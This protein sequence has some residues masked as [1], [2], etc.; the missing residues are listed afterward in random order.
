MP[1]PYQNL[2]DTAFWRPAVADRS[3]FDLDALWS[4]K[5]TVRPEDGVATYG[6]CFAQHIGQALHVRGF[7]WTIAEAAP[8]G[9][10]RDLALKYS[11]GVFS[12]RTGNIY[13]T[14]LLNQWV[15]W[16]N[17]DR[18]APGEV[19]SQDGR[20]VDPF[21]PA[22]EP[23]GFDSV[24]E[25]R[26]SREHAIGR[27]RASLETSRFLVFTLGLTESWWA[28]GGEYEYPMCPGTVAGTF[29]DKAHVFENQGF[30]KV[31]RQLSAALQGVRA[32]NPSIRVIL[33]VS[34]VPL[35]ATASGRHVLVATMHS[36]SILRAVA[37]Q[38]AESCEWIDYFPSY[39][40][41]N[42]PAVGGVFFEPN[43]RNVNPAGVRFVMDQFFR[44]NGI[45]VKKSSGATK[46]KD[47][48][49]RQSRADEVCEEALLDAFSSS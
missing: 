24:D 21:R 46:K 34:P 25:L 49:G 29:D 4:P 3:L 5:F 10:P 45:T 31:R 13:T 8:L 17:G 32:I 33:T 1:N 7:N 38:M 43:K 20:W 42:S 36:K 30:D 18:S 44:S 12:S 16:A 14:S 23:G 28:A 22:I 11:Y 19:W 9:C 39:E 6:S 35:T 47:K 41:I 15:Q 37:G 2:E 40:I 48:P 26:Q 27:F